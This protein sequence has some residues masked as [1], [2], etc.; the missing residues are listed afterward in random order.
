MAF[1]NWKKKE[2]RSL[3]NPQIPISSASIIDFLGMSGV[4]AA[5][6]SV[7]L[8]N[9]LEV[10]A[11][12]AAVNFL[13]GTL[14]GLPLHVFKK[15]EAG[16]ERVDDTLSRILHDAVNNEMSSF[17]WRKY[18]FER[19]LTGGRGLTFIERNA[20]GRVIN[21]WPLDPSNVRV[22]LRGGRKFYSYKEGARTVDYEAR[23]IIDVPFMLESDMV[24]AVSPIL[25][26][27]DTIGMAIA[28]TNYGS[29]FFQGGGVP[30][31]VLVGNFQSSA[32]MKRA[33]DDLELAVKK[34]ARE[35]RLAL[36]LPAGHEL[37]QI[38]ADPEKSQLTEVKRFLIEEIARIYSMPPTF[39][40]DLTHGTFSNSEQQD[41]HFT[42]HTIKRWAEQFEQEL[43]LKLFGRSVSNMYVEMNLDGLL[44]GD[45]STRMT[46]YATAIQNAIMTP[47]EV[48]ATENRT[49]HDKGG[50]L[51]IQGATVPLG[52]QNTQTPPQATDK[53]APDNEI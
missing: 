11:V 4:S 45:F 19:A 44:R 51:M 10:P 7:S 36:T 18:L 49:A 39:L 37:K 46:G 5:G 52:T 33:R 12:F 15:T 3:E 23:D 9:A 27:R 30:P 2:Q 48:R 14:A 42:K 26:N 50:D 40:Q 25:K 41:L 22:T 20:M 38:G 35:N 47:N 21:L 6:V 8:Q 24:T 32:G 1:W 28:A 17:A 16:R 53:E 34:A 31:F 29:K 43:N 13:S